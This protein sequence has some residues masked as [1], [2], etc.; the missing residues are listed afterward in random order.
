VTQGDPEGRFRRSVTHGPALRARAAAVAVALAAGFCVLALL[1]T[2]G[3]RYGAS[4]Q[5]FYVPAVLQHVDP[6]LYPRDRDV[7]SAEARFMVFDEAMAGLLEAMPVSAAHLF[8][9]AYIVTLVALAVT[10]WSFGRA[11]FASGWT[12]AALVLALSLRH[13][14]A[15]TGVNTLESNFHPR[16]LAFA[17]GVGALSACLRGRWWLAAALALAAVPLHPTTGLWFGGAT[18][19]TMFVAEPRTRR[20]VTVSAVIAAAAGAWAVVAGP[21]QGRLV[22]MDSAWLE[23][24][25]RKDYLFPTDWSIGT[26]LTNLLYPAAIGALFHVRRRTGVVTDPERGL[27]AA[28]AVLFLLFLGSLPFTQARIALAVQLQVPRALWLLDFVA[29][30]LLVWLVVEGPWQ[31]RVREATGPAGPRR[32][33]PRRWAVALVAALALARGAY[34]TF[35][36]RQGDPLL[37]IDVPDDDWGRAMRW[38]DARTPVDAFVLADPGHAW[39]Y[40]SSVRMAARRDVYLEEVKDSALGMYSPE[41]ARRVLRRI[42]AV[43]D[44]SRLTAGRALELSQAEGLDYLVTESALDLPVAHR[45]GRLAVYRLSPA[46]VPG[47]AR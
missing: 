46:S 24:L 15:K 20:A 17:V 23:S 21:L 34:V 5:A 39:R 11:L 22:V 8:L 6:L 2:G 4:D 18:M 36:E 47:S 45:A 26:W 7:L 42:Q 9:A 32:A 41:L 35:V 25:A 1:N 3:Y 12:A 44:F 13:R 16:V 19:V 28:M 37:T 10:T 14:I 40:G 31:R 29:T 33:G 27:M 30:A 38:L 43:D